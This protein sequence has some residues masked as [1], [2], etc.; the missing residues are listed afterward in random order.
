MFLILFILNEYQINSFG[1]GRT[2]RLERDTEIEEDTTVPTLFKKNTTPVPDELSENE[3][4]NHD[5]YNHL[6]KHIN[7]LK[8]ITRPTKA[9][10]TEITKV[11][12][13]FACLEPESQ[14]AECSKIG[15]FK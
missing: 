8:K 12:N 3:S 14:Y 9:T 4:E 10:R 1:T 5:A 15:S 13:L 7:S 11:Q 6:E 2:G